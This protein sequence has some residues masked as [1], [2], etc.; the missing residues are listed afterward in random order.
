MTTRLG[1]KSCPATKNPR[2]LRV[3]STGIIWRTLQQ[4]LARRKPDKARLFSGT[5][6]NRQVA[7]PG[8]RSDKLRSRAEQPQ[9]TSLRDDLFLPISNLMRIEVR[10]VI[11]D[12]ENERSNPSKL[13]C[14]AIAC[15]ACF[16]CFARCCC[17]FWVAEA[18]CRLILCALPSHRGNPDSSRQKLQDGSRDLKNGLGVEDVCKL[19]NT[20]KKHPSAN[21]IINGVYWGYNMF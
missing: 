11:F 2:G 3:G 17:S 12:S 18:A 5:T 21:L 4:N 19:K 1:F 9:A 15:F 20:W 6:N 8:S 10:D 7:T 16:A 13:S 14:L